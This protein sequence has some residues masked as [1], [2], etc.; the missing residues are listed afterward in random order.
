MMMWR[1]GWIKYCFLL[2]KGLLTPWNPWGGHG[3]SLAQDKIHGH[4]TSSQCLS[5]PERQN[6]RSLKIFPTSFN[7]MEI[8]EVS[9]A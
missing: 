8:Y 7:A 5:A 6:P 3:S 2:F 4:D 9:I 1:K